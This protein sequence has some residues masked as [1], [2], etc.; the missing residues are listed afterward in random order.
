MR[1]Y[2]IVWLLAFLVMAAVPAFGADYHF[3]ES[4]DNEISTGDISISLKEYGMDE[5]GNLIPYENHVCV[6]P[7]QKV[8]KIVKIVNEGE[9]AWIRVKGEF[10]NE[11]KLKPAE[12]CIMSGISEK[13]IRR[14]A[15][16][17]WKEPVKNLEELVFFNGIQIPQNW[18]EKE[19]ELNFSV[20]V[21][22]QAIQSAHFYPDFSSQD[23][24]FGIPV[25]ECI[26][27]KH[28][29]EKKG[30]EGNF[31]IVFKNGSEGF[32]KTGDDFF[33]GFDA[34]M[35]G[36][37][38]SDSFILG[39]KTGKKLQIFFSSEI[40]GEQ[41][42]AV[43]N[44]L[45]ALVLT[46]KKG[47]NLIYEGPLSGETLKKGI[48]LA[49]LSGNC[50]EE[51]VTYSLYMPETLQNESAM[52]QAKVRWI[53]STRYTKNSSSHS[54]SSDPKPWKP[55]IMK[56]EMNPE[57]SSREITY[58]KIL[59]GGREYG[60]YLGQDFIL[61]LFNRVLPKT[62]DERQ[63]LGFWILGILVG[64]MGLC[65]LFAGKKKKR[66]GRKENSSE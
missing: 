66:M 29:W 41:P 8:V 16:Y 19:A 47:E 46:I 57:S 10:W 50:R 6:V 34:L 35:P 5:N 48:L 25:E 56:E 45:S 44:L 18:N 55:E 13:W 26:H 24:W 9:S 20:T 11:G 30:Q 64:G 15:Y 58:G 23:P 37:R 61:S 39:N 32:L 21:T 7:N 59:I 60:G 27:T 14:G 1:K 42:D 36:D 38:V 40:L 63:F 49:E 22:A 4:V 51:N 65:V 53:F 17:Y 52:K 3:S 33:S 2:F 62:G 28:E 31:G 54:D 43:K 12:D